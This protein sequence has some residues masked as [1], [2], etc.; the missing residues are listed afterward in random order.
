MSIK[1]KSFVTSVMI[2]MSAVYV[3]GLLMISS[4]INEIQ[5]SPYLDEIYHLP[6]AQEY[7]KGNFTHVRCNTCNHFEKNGQQLLP[8]TSIQ[9]DNR[10]TTL[11]GLYLISV[12]VIIP[13]SKW[14]DESLC[15]TNHLRLTNVVLS[16]SNLLV[17]VWL[18]RN[19]HQSSRVRPCQF[20][21]F[22]TNISH[23]AIT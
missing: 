11:P 15:E 8:F 12:G 19:I 21:T 6:Q 17:Y 16:L 20:I 13:L 2:C 4:H 10:I 9:W 3:G 1:K 14:F 5:P 22:V 23:V 18:T 7:C